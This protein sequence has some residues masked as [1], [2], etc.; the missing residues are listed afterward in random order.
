[1]V[2]LERALSVTVP[3]SVK[4][5]WN[6]KF[7][8][9]WNAYTGDKAKAKRERR[10]RLGNALVSAIGG[11]GIM[12]RMGLQLLKDKIPLTLDP[13]VIARDGGADRGDG[14][15][16]KKYGLQ[17]LRLFVPKAPADPT[18]H[19]RAEEPAAKKPRKGSIG[20]S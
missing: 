18:P 17:G 13:D 6:S 20:H 19:L 2:D 16:V 10:E 4:E 14:S 1:M 5:K 8:D 9:L 12:S 11:P 3:L 15:F 7:R